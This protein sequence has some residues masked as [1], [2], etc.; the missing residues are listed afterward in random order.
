VVNITPQPASPAQLLI[1]SDGD[2]STRMGCST[3]AVYID[4][5][6]RLAMEI[7]Y[8]QGPPTEIALVL[9]WRKVSG[10]TASLDASCG[11][12]GNDTFF[13]SSPYT[14]FTSSGY[15]KLVSRGWTVIAPSNFIAPPSN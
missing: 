4:D 1:N 11:S 9:M 6:T 15:S 3:Q 8:Y 7:K 2:H 10:P 5:T 13:G 14:N 12:A